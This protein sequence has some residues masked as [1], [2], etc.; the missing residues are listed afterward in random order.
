MDSSTKWSESPWTL[1]QIDWIIYDQ[2]LNSRTAFLKSSKTTVEVFCELQKKEHDFYNLHFEF[3]SRSMQGN[4]RCGLGTPTEIYITRDGTRSVSLEVHVTADV[5][6][7]CWSVVQSTCPSSWTVIT[8][9]KYVCSTA[10]FEC[11][12]LRLW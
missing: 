5:W 7:T 2:I 10:V 6:H 1:L 3:A 11:L 9:P 8:C 12:L 4:Q